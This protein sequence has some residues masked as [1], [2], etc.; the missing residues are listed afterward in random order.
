M[1]VPHRI[2]TPDDPNKTMGKSLAERDTGGEAFLSP[3]AAFA[4]VSS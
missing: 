1:N 2:L 3:S 4:D